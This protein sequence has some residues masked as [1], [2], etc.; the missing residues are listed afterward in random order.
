MHLV[1]YNSIYESFQKA[2]SKH[3]GLAVVGVFLQVTQLKLFNTSSI[4]FKQRKSLRFQLKL[5]WKVFSPIQSWIQDSRNRA[6]DSSSLEL[7]FRISTFSGIPIPWTVFC[8]PKL[9]ISTSE[10]FS[11]SGNR[12]PSEVGRPSWYPRTKFTDNSRG[13]SRKIVLLWLGWGVPL[14]SFLR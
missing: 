3:D 6:P 1:F 2:V 8:I 4:L 14:V 12:I 7:G 5:E 11:N 9:K 10:M 13:E